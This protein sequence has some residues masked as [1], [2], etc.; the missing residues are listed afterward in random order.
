MRT[1]GGAGAW[2]RNHGACVHGLCAHAPLST[3]IH[4][5]NDF[6]DGLRDRLRQQ[7]PNGRVTGIFTKY[8]TYW[9]LLL[10]Q[11]QVT[12][13]GYCVDAP[14]GGGRSKTARDAGAAER[15]RTKKEV[16]RAPSTGGRT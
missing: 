11:R 5:S 10:E 15:G 16:A 6:A 7:C 3:G 14:T 2:G 13:K 1:E 4:F 8:E 9:Y 12:A